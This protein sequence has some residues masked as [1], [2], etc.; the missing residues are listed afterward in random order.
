MY[1][2]IK[3]GGHQYRVA[4]GD[5]VVVDRLSGKVGEIVTVPALLVA[6]NSDVK[7][8]T[9]ASQTPV[10][11]KIVSHGQGEKVH[12][13]RFRAKSRTRRHTGFRSQLTEITVEAI[14]TLKAQALKKTPAKATAPVTSAA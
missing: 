6:D 14:G 8:G 2:V 7:I 12:V 1:A 4:P 10:T 3:L 13:R 9:P 5:R 11:V